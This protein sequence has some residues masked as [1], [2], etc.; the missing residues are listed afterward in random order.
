M[1]VLFDGNGGHAFTFVVKIAKLALARR[2]IW[3]VVDT[4][5]IFS[6]QSAEALGLDLKHLI[7]LRPSVDDDAWAFTQ[8]LQSTDMGVCFWITR[9]MDNMVFRRLQLAA[10]R[11][12][13]LGFVFRPVSAEHK[14]CWADLRLKTLCFP[15]DSKPYVRV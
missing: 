15:S 14:P 11:G 13:G 9:Q 10:E 12:G 7:L 6:P 4:E 2:K 1:E 8:L 3:A 5:G